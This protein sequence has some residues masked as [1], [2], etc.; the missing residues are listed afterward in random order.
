MR[1]SGEKVRDG[2][3]MGS[4]GFYIYFL[5]YLIK[6]SDGQVFIRPKT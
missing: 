2:W 6:W 4:L 3:V 1:E 5:I